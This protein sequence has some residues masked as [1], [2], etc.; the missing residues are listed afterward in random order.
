MKT[1]MIGLMLLSVQLVQAADLTPKA[2]SVISCVSVG[3]EP[4]KAPLHF[5]ARIAYQL[6]TD[7]NVSNK[8]SFYVTAVNVED[9]AN[10]NKIVNLMTNVTPVELE[11]LSNVKSAQFTGV[12]ADGSPVA[13]SLTYDGTFSVASLNWKTIH[14]DQAWISC[15]LRVL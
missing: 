8:P 3:A 5:Y 7:E 12:T 14:V 1:L 11:T 10:P 4:G 9:P 15:T 13:F 2:N 6:K